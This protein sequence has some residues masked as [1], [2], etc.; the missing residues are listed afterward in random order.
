MSWAS[1]LPHRRSSGMSAVCG[2]LPP[3]PQSWRKRVPVTPGLC[4]RSDHPHTGDLRLKKGQSG[5]SPILQH[6]IRIYTRCQAQFFT[7]HSCWCYL[8]PDALLCH[9]VSLALVWVRSLQRRLNLTN[10]P[11]TGLKKAQMKNTKKNTTWQL[12]FS[13]AG[14]GLLGPSTVSSPYHWKGQVLFHSSCFL[15]RPKNPTTRCSR[16][17]ISRIEA[18]RKNIYSFLVSPIPNARP[19]VGDGGVLQL[20]VSHRQSCRP[21]PAAGNAGA[22]HVLPATCWD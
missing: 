22:E 21:Q 17:D 15:L 12:Q 11:C 14:L 1:S 9:I 19:S 7:V 18:F 8:G 13:N 16:T 2:G 20:I 10:Q 4:H 6:L 5:T 3:P